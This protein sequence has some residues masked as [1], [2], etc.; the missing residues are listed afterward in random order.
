MNGKLRCCRWILVGSHIVTSSVLGCTTAGSSQPGDQQG[1][2]VQQLPQFQQR[3]EPKAGMCFVPAVLAGQ[4][5]KHPSRDC[6]SYF[7]PQLDDDTVSRVPSQSTDE[8]PLLPIKRMVTIMNGHQGQFMGSM[9][10]P[11]ATPLP[12]ISLRMAM[13]S[14]RSR[15][16]SATGM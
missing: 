1:L 10:M 15:N 7:I 9:L 5:I 14:A 3:R 8:L 4:G 13:T 12:R 2:T 11:I 6:Y 16:C